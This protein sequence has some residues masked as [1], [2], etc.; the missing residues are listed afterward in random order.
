LNRTPIAQ[1]I[2]TITDKGDCTK[3]KSFCIAKLIINIV[4]RQSTS[5]KKTLSDTHP[6]VDKYPEYAEN[7]KH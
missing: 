1:E 6:T 4:K 3:L 7:Q 2:I 5:Q